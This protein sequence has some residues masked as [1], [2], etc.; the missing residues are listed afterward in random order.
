MIFGVPTSEVAWLVAG[1]LGGGV[2]TGLMAGLF[3]IGGGAVIVPVLFEVFRVVGVPDEDLG[4]LRMAATPFRLSRTPGRI[5]WAGPRLGAHNELV[6]GRLGLTPA[7]LR[8]LR[9]RGVI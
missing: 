5:R 4:P 7:E 1:I 6:Y 9:E 8:T 2:V 3:G